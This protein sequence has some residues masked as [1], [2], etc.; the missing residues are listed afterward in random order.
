MKKACFLIVV[1][2]I[3]ILLPGQKVSHI[4]WMSFEQLDSAF[5][6]NPKKTL[7]FFYTDWCVYCKK[8]ERAALSKTDIIV[9]LNAN[10]YAVKMDAEEKDIVHFDGTSFSNSAIGQKK[11]GYHD[12]AL[13]LGSR[14]NLPYSLP[15]TIVLDENFQIKNRSF[16]YVSPQMM[17][18]FLG[19]N[20]PGD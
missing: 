3:P 2:L 19:M 13:L 8:M 18:K 7:L 17:R 4:D 6:T 5:D 16:E 12:L 14:P 11:R 9:A 1:I 15:V 10:Y 20:Q